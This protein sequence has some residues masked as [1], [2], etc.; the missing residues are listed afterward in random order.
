MTGEER[1]N[2][3][4]QKLQETGTPLSGTALAKSFRGF[5]K[6]RKKLRLNLNIKAKFFP[7]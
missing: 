7:K 6:I 5:S 3:I 1:R 2:R 4:L